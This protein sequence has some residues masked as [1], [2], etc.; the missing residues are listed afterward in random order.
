MI[1]LGLAAV[2]S[3]FLGRPTWF[4]GSSSSS[5]SFEMMTLILSVVSKSKFSVDSSKESVTEATILLICSS[6]SSAFRSLGMSGMLMFKV[7]C[8]NSVSSEM[9]GSVTISGSTVV[10][11]VTILEM[12]FC[13]CSCNLLLSAEVL[14]LIGMRMLM[15]ES[16]LVSGSSVVNPYSP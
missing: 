16:V 4:T 7:A 14:S 1:V 15:K 13:N 6:S 2:F 5:S 9:K 10:I 11:S 8:S 3:N 12:R